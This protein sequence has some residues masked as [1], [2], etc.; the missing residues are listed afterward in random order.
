MIK[1]W[2][3]FFQD[4]HFKPQTLLVLFQVETFSDNIVNDPPQ[5]N[6]DS[7]VLDLGHVDG[8]DADV[9]HLDVTATKDTDDTETLRPY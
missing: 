4:I 6:G 7:D 5:F 9:Q 8:D 2:G 1:K 3:Y